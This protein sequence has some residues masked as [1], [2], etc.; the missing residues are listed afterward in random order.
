MA[1]GCSERIRPTT[2]VSALARSTKRLKA[3]DD[4]GAYRAILGRRG[5][6]E[7][8][9]LIEVVKIQAFELAPQVQTIDPYVIVL[10]EDKPVLRTATATGRR[11]A[12]WRGFKS[13]DRGVN[14]P[15]AFRGGQPLFF[16]SWDSNYSYDA[17]IGGLVV[18]PDG[19]DSAAGGSGDRVAEYTAKILW[20]WKGPQS[21]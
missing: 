21:L 13:T 5:D 6:E 12:Q 17:F 10:D 16:E 2:P 18:Y 19:D 3:W 11:E 14:Q 1:V 8:D 4:T 7:D 9:Q 15:R 20:D